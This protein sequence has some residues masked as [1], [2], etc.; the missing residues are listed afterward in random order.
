MGVGRVRRDYAITSNDYGPMFANTTVT[1]GAPLGFTVEGHGEYLADEVAALGLGVARRVGPIGTASLAF[2]SSQADIGTGWLA[3]VGFEHQNSLFNVMLRSRMQSREFRE[4]GSI[5]LADPIMERR[6]ASVGVNSTEGSKLSLAYATQTTWAR[7]RSNVLALKQSVSVGR[8]SLSMSAGHS[9]ADNFG[10]SLF[11]SYKRPLGDVCTAP[12]RNDRG[13]R[14][15]LMTRPAGH[16]R[17]AVST[18]KIPR[19]GGT[20]KPR[21]RYYPDAGRSRRPDKGALM[22]TAIAVACPRPASF[23]CPRTRSSGGSAS[24]T[25]AASATSR[26]CTRKTCAWPASMRRSTCGFPWALPPG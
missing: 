5:T 19:A 14:P 20:P 4:V 8:G 12:A 24:P 22:R 1:C 9:L 18:A 16:R 21:R 2:A 23:P 17:V 7:E 10:S 11:I 13:V 3:R 15:G 6:L 25:R 26:I